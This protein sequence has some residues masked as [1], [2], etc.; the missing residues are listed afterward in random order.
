MRWLRVLRA[1]VRSA[2]QQRGRSLWGRLRLVLFPSCPSRA[3]RSATLRC[4]APN[5]G[6]VARRA[7]CA[8]GTRLAPARLVAAGR[9]ER[10]LH[11]VL[12]FS[13]NVV[14][15]VTLRGRSLRFA[16]NGTRSC[17][18][19]CALLLQIKNAIVLNEHFCASTPAATRTSASAGSTGRLRL[20]RDA[21]LVPLL[22]RAHVPIAE[23]REIG[24]P[25][26]NQQH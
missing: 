20:A 2:G 1:C 11:C 3:F 17:W 25:A 19:V 13:S 15:A 18:T 7:R 16:R 6:R 22:Q 9:E 14:G 24:H 5:A 12:F 4:L 23:Q 10:A 26:D 21:V 8:G